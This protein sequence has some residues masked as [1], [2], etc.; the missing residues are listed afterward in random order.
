MDNC[1]LIALISVGVTLLFPG[2]I[3][4][5]WQQGC[6]SVGSLKR[7]FSPSTPG[8]IAPTTAVDEVSA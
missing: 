4:G 6:D 5:L 7:R 2:G 3:V 8:T 1:T